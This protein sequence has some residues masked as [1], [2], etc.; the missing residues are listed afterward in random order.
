MPCVVRFESRCKI[1]CMANIKVSMRGCIPQDVDI[2]KVWCW[3]GGSI[4]DSIRNC[5]NEEPEVRKKSEKGL[6]PKRVM[7]RPPARLRVS[8]SL[9]FWGLRPLR[10]L[11]PPGDAEARLLSLWPVSPKRLRL[12]AA[13]S[14]LS[15]RRKTAY[16][17]TWYA[18]LRSLE[19]TS[20]QLGKIE[21]GNR[22]FSFFLR[23]AQANM[24]SHYNILDRS[25]LWN[26]L[27]NSGACHIACKRSGKMKYSIRKKQ[28]YRRKAFL[29]S[30]YG[31]RELR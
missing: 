19:L 7:R 6:D 2:V 27:R 13:H 25:V 10:V 21:P 18:V 14:G 4:G 12:A 24:E 9:A 26:R 3:H 28:P 1:W 20:H 15:G 30:V 29:Y 22:F 16:Q 5:K 31:Q 11:R 8:L 17:V 23:S